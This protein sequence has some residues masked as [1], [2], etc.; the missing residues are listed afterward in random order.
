MSLVTCR[1][2]GD[3]MTDLGAGNWFKLNIIRR[4]FQRTSA[5]RAGR[6][7]PGAFRTEANLLLTM[8]AA[9]MHVDRLAFAAPP[10]DKLLDYHDR[11]PR[12]FTY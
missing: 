6:N 10:V 11:V 12:F 9:Y 3:T 5:A 1:S 8:L 4:E 2:L 7:G